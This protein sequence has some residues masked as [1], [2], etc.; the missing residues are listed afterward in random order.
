VPIRA[1]TDIAFLGGLI[2]YVLTNELWFRE[3]VLAYTNATSIIDKRY[4]DAEELGGFFVGYDPKTR[5]Y[6][7][8]FWQYAEDTA[9]TTHEPHTLKSMSQSERSGKSSSNP[10]AD[11]TLRDPGC[12]LNIVRRHFARY[13]PEAVASICG[14]TVAQFLE[15]ACALTANSG[16]ERTSSIVYAVGWTQHT[17]GV[18]TIR[19]AG[20]LQLLLGNIGRPG[21]GIMAM[22]GHASIQGSTDVSTLYDVLPGYL[23]MPT[24]SERHS[25]LDEYLSNETPRT[26]YW[27]RMPAFLISLLKAWY[28]EHASSSNEFAYSLLPRLEGEWSQ[29]AMFNEMT[30]TRP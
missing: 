5:S 25:S 30:P 20:I 6:D 26:G 19:A 7:P 28:G 3:Y 1:G 24:T 10:V 13:T 15:V 18:Q 9:P 22:R 11:P 2:N 23:K 29:L 16:R 27:S 12:V 21:G 4:V 17:T 8:A 14:C